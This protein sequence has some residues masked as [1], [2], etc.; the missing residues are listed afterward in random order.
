MKRWSGRRTAYGIALRWCRLV[1]SPAPESRLAVFHRRTHAK[2][3]SE[4]RA[5]ACIWQIMS[6]LPGLARILQIHWA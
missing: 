2:H 4:S 5:L 3:Q 1:T 6:Y